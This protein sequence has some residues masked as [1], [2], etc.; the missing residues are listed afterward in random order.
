MA[1]GVRPGYNPRP[2]NRESRLLIV[3]D[4]PPGNFGASRVALEVRAVGKILHQYALG[5]VAQILQSH[6]IVRADQYHEALLV[7]RRR[8]IGLQRELRSV[9]SRDVGTASKVV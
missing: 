1:A 8:G 4:L 9:C 2:A 6:R 7:G 3:P 5:V